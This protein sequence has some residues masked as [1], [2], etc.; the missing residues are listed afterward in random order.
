MS[1]GRIV[2]P[3]DVVEDI[4]AR[5]LPG[6]IGAAVAPLRLHR[7]KETLHDGVVPHVARPTHASG[8]AQIAQHVLKHLARVL[9]ALI[10][11]MQHAL[12][13]AP[14]PDRHHQRVRHEL[15]R[16]RGVH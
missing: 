14:P 13:G 10:R 2:E 6:G 16:H 11:V 5:R 3:L 12:G 4:C 9:T 1:P 8:H 15:G 7:G